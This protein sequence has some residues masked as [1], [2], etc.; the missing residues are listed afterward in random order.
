MQLSHNFS[1]EELIKSPTG[2]RFGIDN[3]PNNERIS[4]LLALAKNI[5]QPVRDNFKS[6]VI[7]NSGYRCEELNK[8]VGSKPTS[9]HI[10][11]QAADFEVMGYTNFE[12][13]KWISKHLTFDQLILEFYRQGQPHSGWI[14]CSYRPDGK[15]RGEVITICE[16][17]T[18][19]GLRE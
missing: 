19:P 14:H 2:H 15:N 12:V 4:N 18:F 3:I 16:T 1:L 7:I 9:Q 11:G 13:A 5:L 10:L 17:G 6:P 8:A